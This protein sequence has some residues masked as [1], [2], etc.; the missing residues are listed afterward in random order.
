MSELKPACLATANPTDA[1]CGDLRRNAHGHN[2]V[3]IDTY[4]VAFGKAAGVC[5]MDQYLLICAMV[6]DQQIL[7]ANLQDCCVH[8]YFHGTCLPS[9]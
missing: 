3:E 1:A 9:E 2:A 8:R 6:A 7:R 4:A 5:R